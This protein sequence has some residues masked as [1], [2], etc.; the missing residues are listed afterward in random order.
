MSLTKKNL[1][2]FVETI[3]QLN[4]PDHATIYAQV[5]PDESVA[6]ISVRDSN[7]DKFAMISIGEVKR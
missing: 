7:G 5:R 3:R 1:I 6:E 4:I 2:D